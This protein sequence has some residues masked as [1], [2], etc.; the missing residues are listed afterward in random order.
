MV[1]QIYRIL[2]G[3]IMTTLF[4]HVIRVYLVN[5]NQ[6][7][8]INDRVHTTNNIQRSGNIEILYETLIIICIILYCVL[9]F[10][11][12]QFNLIQ[13][14]SICIDLYWIHVDFD[15]PNANWNRR[16]LYFQTL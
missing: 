13:F 9:W 10:E 2:F 11:S 15:C 3:T 6:I 7:S 4:L 14:D 8:V 5:I 16:E 12:F 1:M